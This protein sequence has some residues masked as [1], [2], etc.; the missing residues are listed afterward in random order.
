MRKFIV[1]TVSLFLYNCNTDDSVS[2]NPINLTENIEVYNQQLIDDSYVLAVEN[3]G[4]A[5]YLLNKEDE[6]IYQKNN[7]TSVTNKLEL[8]PNGKLSAIF[9]TQENDIC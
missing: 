5:S 1:I 6:I 7:K 3:G 9:K 8:I 2:S 4:N